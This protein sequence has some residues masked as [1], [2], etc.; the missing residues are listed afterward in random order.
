MN[1]HEAYKAV[2]RANMWKGLAYVAG[3]AAIGYAIKVTKSAMPLWALLLLSA[4]SMLS[5]R[6]VPGTENT[7]DEEEINNEV[8]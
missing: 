4:P 2:T 3:C 8:K 5:S 6:A 1:G 7:K